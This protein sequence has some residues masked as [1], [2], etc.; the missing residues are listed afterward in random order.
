MSWD[1]ADHTHSDY[2]ERGHS[3]DHHELYGVAEQYHS[4]N[5]LEHKL[6]EALDRIARLEG[7]IGE[8]QDRVSESCPPID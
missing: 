8:L 5:D 3:H 4:H 1:D 6:S 2:A 7:R